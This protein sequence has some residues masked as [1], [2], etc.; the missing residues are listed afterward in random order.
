M[1]GKKARWMERAVERGR[2]RRERRVEVGEECGGGRGV[3]R[4]GWRGGWRG[5]WRGGWRAGEGWLGVDRAGER[6]GF[7][8]LGKIV[9][10]GV[11]LGGL[12][13]GGG[14]RKWSDE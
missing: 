9:G 10:P 7:V 14:M 1:L 11:R 6:K 4:G 12:E 8:E 13:R 3:W 5:E 2:G